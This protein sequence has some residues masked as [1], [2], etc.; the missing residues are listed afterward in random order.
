[1]NE[2]KLINLIDFIQTL[3]N[4]RYKNIIIYSN[5]IINRTDFAVSF[6]KKYK[7]KY[8]D[9]LDKFNNDIDLKNDIEF[10]NFEKLK[11]LLIKESENEKVLMIDKIDFLINTWDSNGYENLL[12]LV[13]QVWNNAMEV[14][15][16]ILIIFINTNITV[17]NC[18]S[19]ER[20]F[21]IKE[22][23]YLKGDQG[24]TR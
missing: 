16:T 6:A 17:L 8:L 15:R 22:L 24:W 11:K 19:R 9:L 20:I 3:K 5:P 18:S 10:F 1:M 4:K 2:K 13:N 12:F 21:D 7:F 23:K 14:Y